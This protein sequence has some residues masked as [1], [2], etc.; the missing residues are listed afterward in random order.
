MHLASDAGTGDNRK[1]RHT[2]Q[3]EEVSIVVGGIGPVGSRNGIKA[4]VACGNNNGWNAEGV[5]RGL[6][7]IGT[8]QGPVADLDRCI[9]GKIEAHTRSTGDIDRAAVGQ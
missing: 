2:R 8:N 4:Q 1:T 7:P 6:D 3:A 9:R 5:D